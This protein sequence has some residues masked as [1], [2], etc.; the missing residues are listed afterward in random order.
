MRV[1]FKTK[2][3]HKEGMGDVTS[4]LVLAEEF[5]S[6]GHEVTVIVNKNK[7]IVDIFAKRGFHCK[8]GES[9]EEL[10]KCI[11]V[12]AVDIAVLNQ[13]NT[14]VKEALIFKNQSKFM[15]TIDDIGSASELADIR[16]NVLYPIENSI[17][18]FEF[19][20]L[21]PIFQEK[22]SI[23]KN[24][25]ETLDSIMVTQGGSDT[26]GF[27]SKIVKALFNISTNVDINI[28]LGPNFSHNIELYE[29]LRNAPRKFT[30]I[31]GKADLSELMLKTDLAI[32]A[33]GITLF[34][35]ACL[36]VPTIVVCGETYEV[37][38]AERLK[39]KGFGINLGFGE[40]INE[41]EI[42]NA[43][44]RLR[45]DFNLRANMTQ[46]GKELIDG[47]GSRK[48]REEIE[49]RFQEITKNILT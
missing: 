22:H 9:L 14:P 17:S 8:T 38:T 48:I 32:S 25:K 21:S 42:Y 1:L 41:N 35:L 33:G 18:G 46:K 11:K 23:D 24:I 26:Y 39:G 44:N 13:L 49:K 3:G 15:V 47:Q 37:A 36:G 4:S 31:K 10:D 43:T 28:I 5:R 40:D 2:G 16:F 30:I 6:I 34:E 29:V 20:A 45:E 19:I 7:N 12:D 27:T